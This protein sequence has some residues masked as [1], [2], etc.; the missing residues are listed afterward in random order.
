MLYRLF[1]IVVMLVIWQSGFANPQDNKKT[2]Q[3]VSISDIHFNPMS[4]CERY[5][6]SCPIL[7]ELNLADYQNWDTIFEKYI[8]TSP[9][10]Y[11]QDTNYAL[12][13]S[14]L[15]ELKSIAEH[16]DPQFVLVLGDFLDHHLQRNYKKY[17]SNP[18]SY[19]MFVKKT[20]QYLTFKLNQTFPTINVYP[21]L[22]NVDTY[23]HD[24]RVIPSGQFLQEMS[25]VWSSLIKDSVNKENFINEFRKGGFYTVNVSETTKIIVLDTVLFSPRAQSSAVKKVAREQLDWLAMQLK[26]AKAKHQ[27]VL[28]ACHIPVGIDIYFSSILPY[29]IIKNFWASQYTKEFLKIV[30]DNSDS[31]VG[32]LPGHVHIDLFQFTME[33]KNNTL[34]PMIFTPSVSPIFGNNPAFKIFNYDP[35]T[36]GLQYFDRYYKPLL[37]DSD[38][39]RKGN[40]FSGIHQTK[41]Q[42]CYLS[43]VVQHLIMNNYLLDAITKYYSKRIDIETDDNNTLNYYWCSIYSNDINA[44][45]KCINDQ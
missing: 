2:K 44:Y 28:I 37:N 4:G 21:V 29:K 6:T 1:S 16:D 40:S 34:I 19:V 31:L 23:D 45:K 41:C 5:K 20:M 43:D 32:V 18:S 38:A 39:W 13:R 26:L 9:I 25:D 17:S 24:Y 42:Y 14:L 10:A 15:E 11:Y 3:F 8:D 12:L 27:S 33:G 30:K 35:A 22:G 36:F 7:H